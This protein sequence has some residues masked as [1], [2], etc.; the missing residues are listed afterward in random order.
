METEHVGLAKK[1]WRKLKKN[2]KWFER[3]VEYLRAMHRSKQKRACKCALKKVGDICSIMKS[4]EW[5][6]IQSKN[7]EKNQN[8]KSKTRSDR[9]KNE[10]THVD[11]VQRNATRS[12]SSSCWY[13]VWRLAFRF[14]PWTVPMHAHSSSP[15]VCVRALIGSNRWVI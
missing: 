4:T 7:G 13:H 11:T 5:I 10:A 12:N 2:P 6:F 3:T 1:N 9:S 14:C 15:P 8:R